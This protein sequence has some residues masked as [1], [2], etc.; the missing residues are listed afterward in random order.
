MSSIATLLQQIED[1]Y[2][3]PV[4][5]ETPLT[6][7][8][9]DITDVQLT[10]TLV[11]DV[12]SPDEENHISA[13]RMLEIDYELVRITAFDEVTKVV[14]CRRGARGTTKA[15]HYAATSEVRIP[16]RWSRQRVIDALS[17]SIEALWQ[18]LFVVAEERAT[19]ETAQ[20]L[21]LPLNTVQI[22]SVEYQDG[23]LEWQT[24]SS[25][26]FS[27]SPLDSTTASVQIGR[28][29]YQSA[30]CVVR[31]GM[32]VTAPDT[33]TEE[34]ELLPAKWDRIVIADAAAQLLAGVDIDAATQERLTEQMR[35]ENFPVRSGSTISQ[36]LIR[37]R[38][39]LVELAVKELV[40]E[41]PREV[42]RRPVS[43]WR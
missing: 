28:L 27:T 18:P 24:V 2:L 14:T 9:T 11:S 43:V 31:Y 20:Y 1:E 13:G 33:I 6:F 4:I 41:Y 35:L 26:L 42:H 16:T 32:K 38:E 21:P 22:L 40:A 17:A 10:F 7:I 5:E 8:T 19:I 25:R 12:F 36:N 23:N 37:Y 29:P 30:L 15:A 34:I 3:E 39:Y